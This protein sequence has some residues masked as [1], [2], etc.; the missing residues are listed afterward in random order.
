M[1]ALIIHGTFVLGA[2][3]L[4]LLEW[5][6]HKAAPGEVSPDVKEVHDTTPKEQRQEKE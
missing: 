2:L 6:S 1:W 3:A 4:G 5:M